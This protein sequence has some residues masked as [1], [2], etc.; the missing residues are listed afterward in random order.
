MELR[1]GQ[2]DLHLLT[3]EE[4]ERILRGQVVPGERWARGYPSA[5]QLDYLRAWAIEAR[6]PNREQHW[7]GQV[8]RR[9]DG[10]VVGG[11][12]I[13]GPVDAEGAVV[14]GYELVSEANDAMSGVDVVRALLG[15]ARGMGATRATSDVF[16]NDQ[17]RRHVYFAAGF[18]ESRREGRVV[19]LAA[20]I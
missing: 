2:L 7:Q 14:I 10:V 9:S 4:T 13:T 17:L 15:L 18:T 1:A 5:M 3:V 6:S 8:R 12:G 11:A 20:D 19:F 16:A